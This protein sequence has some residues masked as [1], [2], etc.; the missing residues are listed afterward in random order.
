MHRLGFCRCAFGEY[1][2][3]ENPCIILCTGLFC[4]RFAG[5]RSRQ[6]ERKFD[7]CSQSKNGQSKRLRF[8]FWYPRTAWIDWTAFLLPRFPSYLSVGVTGV[9]KLFGSLQLDCIPAAGRV[10]LHLYAI[11]LHSDRKNDFKQRKQAPCHFGGA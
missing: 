8:Y 10:P 6:L 4:S 7:T 3:T 5:T 1:V 2:K 9:L 11:R